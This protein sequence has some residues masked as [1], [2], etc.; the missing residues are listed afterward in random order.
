MTASAE[1]IPR[2]AGTGWTM[3]HDTNGTPGSG[4][5][6]LRMSRNM[7]RVPLLRGLVLLALGVLLLVDPLT[8]LANLVPLF[9][10]FLLLDGVLAAVQGVVT[11]QETGWRWWLVQAAV[12]VVFAATIFLWPQPTALVLFYLLLVWALALGI[13]SIIGGVALARNRDLGWPWLL[14]TGI[15]STLFGL[16]LVTKAQ[17]SGIVLELVVV[18]FG[19][20]AFVIGAV[21]IVSVF[22]MR[23]VAQAIDRALAGESLVVAGVADRRA[24][25]THAADRAPAELEG[26]P[27]ASEGRMLDDELAG[28]GFPDTP[29]MIASP[30][31]PTVFEDDDDSDDADDERRPGVS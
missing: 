9:S 3:T 8:T 25:R 31:P 6:A 4:G 20:Y 23:W 5:S 11:R 10:V 26:A 15:I 13:V 29:G 27:A 28:V 16:M 17:S 19:L 21:H 30:A 2:T 24:A 1:V 18:V 7:W 14:T 22:A 12:S